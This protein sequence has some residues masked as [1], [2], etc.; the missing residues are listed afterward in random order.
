MVAMLIAIA[1]A[2]GLALSGGGEAERYVSHGA[3]DMDCTHSG[4]NSD[5][6]VQF[7]L[8]CPQSSMSP[9]G[10]WLFVQT[11]A[12]G[13]E[14]VYDVL[15]ENRNGTPVGEVP[16]L[17]DAMPYALLWAPRHDWFMVNHHR[18]SGLQ[19]PRLFEITPKGI[20]EHDRH[21]RA[22]AAK[23]REI[24]PCLPAGDHWTTGDGLKWSKDGRRI[25]WIFETRPDMC[26]FL[27]HR[28]GPI[29]P[30]KRWKAFLM[31]SDVESGALIADSIRILPVDGKWSFPDDGP[32]RDF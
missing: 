25:A 6:S 11:P 21:L 28:E 24:S 19:R 26:V 15:I 27:T 1:T 9:D 18:G 4:K 13:P 7:I 2:L 3:F 30:D 20:V 23:A 14:E 8:T 10:R 29:P 32:Y 31:I 22:A 12:V 16:N 5:G 17:D